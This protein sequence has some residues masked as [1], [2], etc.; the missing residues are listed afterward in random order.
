MARTHWSDSDDLGRVQR[1]LF[2]S[3]AIWTIG[4]TVL[5]GVIGIALYGFGVFS[6]DAKGRGDALKQK[7][8]ATNRIFAQ[9][10][11][12]DLFTELKA[13]DAKL[14]QAKSDATSG[15]RTAQ[16]NFTGLTNH[17]LDV[18]AQYDAEAR[19]YL[20][21]QFRAAD[22]PAKIDT[23]DPTTDCKPTDKK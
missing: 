4:L 3:I 7:N 9:A 12:E 14:D 10:T 11:F 15:D 5:M 1:G 21:A 13:T 22:L 8:S 16:T 19:K 6:S 18:I 20:T 2:G 17:C 23:L